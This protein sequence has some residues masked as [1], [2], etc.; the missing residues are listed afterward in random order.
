VKVTCSV[1]PHHLALDDS[2]L[3]SFDAAFKVSPPLRSRDHIDALIAGLKDGTIDAIS[4]DHQPYSVEKKRNELDQAPFGIAG[5]ETA[6]PICL[7]TLIEPGHLTWLELIDKLSTR[8]AKIL[9]LTKGTLGDGA[10]ADVTLIDPEAEWTVDPEAFFSRG[11]NT[12]FA[13]WTVK[14]RAQTVIVNGQTRFQNG[15]LT[16]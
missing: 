8:P 13:G 16:R 12:P 7:Q 6:I 4:S 9:G 5:L 10:T 1:T 11:R 2:S 3:T 14:G 15:Q